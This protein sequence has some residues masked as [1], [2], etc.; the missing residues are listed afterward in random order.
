M[1]FF[2]STKGDP[3]PQVSKAKNELLTLLVK[4][5]GAEVTVKNDYSRVQILGEHFFHEI[6]INIAI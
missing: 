2:K 5:P 1:V 3:K 6:P 4:T